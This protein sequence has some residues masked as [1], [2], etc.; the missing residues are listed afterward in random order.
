MVAYFK[1]QSVLNLLNNFSNLSTVAYKG[2]AYKK[3]RVL[4]IWNSEILIFWKLTDFCWFYTRKTWKTANFGI[5]NN[6]NCHKSTIFQ[7]VKNSEL[8]TFSLYQDALVQI[9]AK[10]DKNCDS[11]YVLSKISYISDFFYFRHFSA[12]F[13]NIR[14]YLTIFGIFWQFLEILQYST[15]F[16][17]IQRNLTYFYRQICRKMSQSTIFTVELCCG[18]CK[19]SWSTLEGGTF[20]GWYKNI[21][22]QFLKFYFSQIFRRSFWQNFR[23]WPSEKL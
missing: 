18:R 12:I 17:I 7:V 6:N 9:S 11:Q 13:D 15:S 5:F 8:K 3:N 2:V 14:H 1:T 20:F 4:T 16:N 22:L 23:L 21:M 19:R 10:S